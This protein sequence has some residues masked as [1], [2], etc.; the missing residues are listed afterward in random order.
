[1]LIEVKVKV[2]RVVD[3]KVRRKTETYLV[4]K[5]FF[6]EA[7]YAVT[8]LMQEEE[9]SH[10]VES[11]EILSLRVS[12]VRE[13]CTQYEGSTSFI[14]TLKDI[15]LTDDGTEKSIKYK[16][17]LWADSLTEA[18]A[19]TNVFARQGYDMLVEGLKEVDYIYLPEANETEDVPN[20]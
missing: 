2:A 3:E 11:S 17:L 18:M 9:S 10:L 19:R 1:M 6:S 5:E 16:V 13:I 15:F 14:A 4:D 20:E 8:A 7:E 12:P